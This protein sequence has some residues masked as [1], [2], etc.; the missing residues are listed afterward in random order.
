MQ[1]LHV[2][3]RENCGSGGVPSKTTNRAAVQVREETK[4]WR[5]I[6]ADI[7]FTASGLS[8]AGCGPIT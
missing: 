4:H 8:S 2:Q 1:W 5:H 6:D 3:L 7:A